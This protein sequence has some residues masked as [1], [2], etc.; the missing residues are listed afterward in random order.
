[1]QDNNQLT[2][3]RENYTLFEFI[4]DVGALFGSLFSISNFILFQM[5]QVG[6]LLDNHLLMGVFRKLKS[7]SKLFKTARLKLS[8]SEWL[9]LMPSRCLNCLR[10][11]KTQH[12]RTMLRRVG[13]RRI[14]R[15][16][17]VVYFLRK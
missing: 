11:S 17:D 2:S 10:L 12:R 4:G 7:K 9:Q 15:E 5:L 1:M 6:V 16:L 8:F 14:D 3:T 13:L